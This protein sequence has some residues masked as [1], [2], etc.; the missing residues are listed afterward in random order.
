MKTQLLVKN[1]Q[2]CLEVAAKKD[3]RYYLNGVHLDYCNELEMVYV[4]TCGSV[5]LAIRAPNPGFE[6]S[7]GEISPSSLIIPREAIATALKGYKAN[8][9]QLESLSEGRYMLGNSVIFA[10]LDG[11]FPDYS[12]VIPEKVSGEAGNYDP[13]LYTRAFKAVSV[14]SRKGKVYIVQ[15]G[16][17]SSAVVLADSHPEIVCVLMPWK[18]RGLEFVYSGWH[19]HSTPSNEALAA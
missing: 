8:S 11:K 4:A 10:P 19:K 2:A 5:L 17:N 6:L 14:A 16:E 12:R 13:E 3:I 15:G 1:L 7:D 9:I 18:A